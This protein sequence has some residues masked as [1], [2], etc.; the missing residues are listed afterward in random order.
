MEILLAIDRTISIS[1][2]V[3]MNRQIDET[4][5]CDSGRVYLFSSFYQ[6]K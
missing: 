3:C 2:K 4:V 6:K 1:D 5:V